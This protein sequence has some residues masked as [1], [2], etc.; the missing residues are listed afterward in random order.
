MNTPYFSIIIPIYNVE[1]YLSQCLDSIVH[2]SF[3]NYEL[4]LVND[5]SKDKSLQICLDYKKTNARIQLIDQLNGGPSSA[6]NNGLNH[7]KGQYIMFIDSDDWI[8]PNT[9]QILYEQ[10]L[11]ECPLI[12]YGFCAQFGGGDS[13]STIHGYRHS[14]NQQQYYSILYHTMENRMHSFSYGFPWNKIFRRDVIEKNSIRFDLRLRVKEDEVFTNQ[15]CT[16]VKEVKIIPY[17]LYN[18]RMSFGN[19]IS[20]CK[21]TPSEYEHMADRLRETSRS[22]DDENI[23]K[24]QHQ[25]YIYNLSKGIT[26]AIRQ[27]NTKEARRLA[28][29]CANKMK[30]MHLSYNSFTRVHFKDK[31]R[32][33]Y[34]NGFWIYLTS[35]LFDRF[36]T[37]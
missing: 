29:K 16:S 18:Y 14:H 4:I 19:S 5:G 9:L 23:Q 26:V 30:E 28:H 27:Q 8:A 24:Y 32:Y 21:R 35:K 15:F 25:E 20:F 33:K 12:Y 34:A 6:R 36:Y 11:D 13:I 17:A 10:S 22:L 7:A 31:I 2:Q 37:I 3:K 1:K